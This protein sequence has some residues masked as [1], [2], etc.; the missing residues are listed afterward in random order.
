MEAEVRRQ[1]DRLR[2][3]LAEFDA[4]SPIAAAEA[5]LAAVEQSAATL[6]AALQALP[7]ESRTHLTSAEL[8]FMPGPTLDAFVDRHLKDLDK[9]L[10]SLAQGARAVSEWDGESGRAARR[11]FLIRG[12]IR[13]FAHQWRQAGLGEPDTAAG[14][15]FFTFARQWLEHAGVR[16]ADAAML[17]AALGSGWRV[18]A[19]GA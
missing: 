2:A 15:P 11:T 12:Y 14:S 10:S 4:G 8:G 5:P 13:G 3:Q 19:K 6:R 9:Q 16:D 7:A 1:A 18:A 17:Q